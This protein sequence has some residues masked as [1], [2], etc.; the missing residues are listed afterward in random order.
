MQVSRTNELK[1]GRGYYSIGR[2]KASS[3]W[4]V[5]GA[6]DAERDRLAAVRALIREGQEFEA[7]AIVG[8]DFEIEAVRRTDFDSALLQRIAAMGIAVRFAEAA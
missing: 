3:G 4:R 7:D 6:H 8:L 5:S 2:I 1:G